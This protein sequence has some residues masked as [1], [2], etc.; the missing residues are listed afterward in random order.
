MKTKTTKQKFVRAIARQTVAP[1]V[2]PSR[3]VKF[4]AGRIADL[5]IHAYSDIDGRYRHKPQPPKYWEDV[6]LATTVRC[7]GDW[8]VLTDLPA[9][10]KEQG[11]QRFVWSP[12]DDSYTLFDTFVP[13]YSF[14]QVRAWF[15]DGQWMIYHYN[16]GNGHLIQ[17]YRRAFGVAVSPIPK[18]N[19]VVPEKAA[20]YRDRVILHFEPGADHA[21][22]QRN[23]MHI[24][25][26][27]RELYPSSKLVLEEFIRRHRDLE[28]VE[29]GFTSRN[30]R[31]AR[32]VPTETTTELIRYVHSG[33][34]FVGCLSGPMHVA[35]ALGLR[36]I[37]IVNFPHAKQIVLPVLRPTGTIE[38]EW[39]YP[40][41]CW[42]HQDNGSSLVPLFNL[43]SLEA[44]FGGDVYPFWTDNWL[45]LIDD[46][47][48]QV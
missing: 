15:V 32:W 16:C 47:S 48:L 12:K 11:L 37:G 6:I 20:R 8:T 34:W 2:I 35:T 29:V 46:Q 3:L 24:H 19:L 45:G 4:S 33:S 1:T 17:K 9:A 23:E 27:P 31:G 42:L 10:A 21:W 39:L 14:P 36:C 7:L 30:I 28:F 38:E 13:G 25:P 43:H 40:Q 18:G 26:Q 22:R 41:H 44:A 5:I